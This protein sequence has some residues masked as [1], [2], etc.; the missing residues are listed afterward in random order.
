MISELNTSIIFNLLLTFLKPWQLM[1][2]H[3]ELVKYSSLLPQRF[4]GHH[5]WLGFLLV[6]SETGTICVLAENSQ[7]HF[8]ELT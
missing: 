5:N 7:C 6:F 4:I 2:P 1:A 8:W 3:I